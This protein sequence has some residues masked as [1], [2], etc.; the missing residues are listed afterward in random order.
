MWLD[1]VSQPLP[2]RW[3]RLRTSWRWRCRR[4]TTAPSQSSRSSTRS[5]RQ[6]CTRSTTWWSCSRDILSNSTLASLLSLMM[7]TWNGYVA[8]QKFTFT[9]FT[10]NYS[11][12]KP[13]P[14]QVK[15]YAEDVA[16][17]YDIID[18]GY[19]KERGT[20]LGSLCEVTISRRS[21]LCSI[22]PP[23]TW[24][25]LL[26][27]TRCTRCWPRGT[28]TRARRLRSS[29]A[30]GSRSAS[31]CSRRPRQATSWC[32]AGL[33]KYFSPE[34]RSG[35]GEEGPKRHLEISDRPEKRPKRSP[36]G[37]T[38]PMCCVNNSRSSLFGEF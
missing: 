6:Y 1:Q 15:K 16:R 38:R 20:I 37:T 34:V 31:T 29:S 11:I 25:K 32:R 10:K 7:R 35:S 17:V 21:L 24:I 5:W 30:W 22:L 23:R 28:W 13:S 3:T 33:Q 9:D 4:W 14:S 36:I 26:N 19:Q 18:P 12:Q 27:P 2:L 8:L